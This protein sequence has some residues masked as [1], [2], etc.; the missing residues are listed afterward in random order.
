M[1][2]LELHLQGI[3]SMEMLTQAG[4]E[5]GVQSEDVVRS[6][7]GSSHFGSSCFGSGAVR[8]LSNCFPLL[9]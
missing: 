1:V 8:P 2:V 6:H 4:E 3:P 7:F 5:G 9:V